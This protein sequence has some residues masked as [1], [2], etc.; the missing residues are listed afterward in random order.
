M[1]RKNGHVKGA[2]GEREVAGILQEWWRRRETAAEFIRTPMSG[3]W[4]KGSTARV[5]FQACGDVMTTSEKFPFCI[6][7]K[8]REAWGVDNLLNGKRTPPW[9][10]WLQTIEAAVEQGSTP[11]MW[12]RRNRLRD[13][14]AFP[15]LV[16]L[17]LDYVKTRR[18]S[19]PDI[20]WNPKLLQQNGVEF[21][22]LPIA[23][24][25]DRF[26]EMAPQRMT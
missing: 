18:L 11:M 17:P 5:H 9:D 25:Y 2:R 7:V 23:Y 3:G 21:G 22:R 12:M 24:L 4:N 15:W 6:E 1:P 10:W 16:W 20:A 13:G 19:D 26:L 14:T 8:W